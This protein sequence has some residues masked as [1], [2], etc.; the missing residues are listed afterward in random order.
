MFN[1]IAI[2]GTNVLFE[3]NSLLRPPGKETQPQD[4][5]GLA[6]KNRIETV[7]MRVE[8]LGEPCVRNWGRFKMEKLCASYR[9]MSPSASS[10]MV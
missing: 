9:L 5:E 7:V 4:E 10:D 8:Y 1:I 3:N 6:A 2:N